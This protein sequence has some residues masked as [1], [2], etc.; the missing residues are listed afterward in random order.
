MKEII[1]AILLSFNTILLSAQINGSITTGIGDTLSYASVYVEGTVRGTIANENGEY[2]LDLEPGD[3][4]IVYQYIG[5]EKKVESITLGEDPLEINVI[6]N[7]SAY[8]MNDI[9]IAADAEDPAYAIMRKA[10]Q[11][12]DVNKDKIQ[13][14]TANVYV[15]GNVKMLDAPEKF[16]GQE[17]GD[18]D[19][20]LDDSTRQGILYLSESQSKITFERP[21]KIKEEMYSSIVSGSDNGINANQFNNARFDFYE[22]Y[23]EFNRSMLSPLAGNA[24]SYYRFRLEGTSYDTDGRLV[25]KIKVIPKS[26]YQPVFLGL[27]YIYEDTWGLH[28]VDLKFSGK[29]VKQKMFDT[30]SIRQIFVPVDDFD[31]L[32]L[33][34]QTMDFTASMFGFT[35]GGVFNYIFSDYQLN[36]SF[37]ENTFGSELFSMTNDARQ[38][39]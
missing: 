29:S 20:I 11:N 12:R 2:N 8:Q 27:I 18:L 38:S 34:S 22:E 15:K 4:N 36:Q 37:E 3:Y 31:G 25:N 23:Q 17:I 16:L 7:E 19:G 6:L 33:M 32:P 26:E 5:Y 10:I 35:V 14:Y 9:V 28:S 21:D 39:K 24:M 30:I 13:S 1:I